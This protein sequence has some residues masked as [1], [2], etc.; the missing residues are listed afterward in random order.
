MKQQQFLD[1]LPLHEA[2]RRWEAA[3]DL[4]P[5]PTE[6]VALDAAHGRTLAEDIVAPGDVPAFDRSNVDGFAVHAVDTFGASERHPVTLPLGGAAI[7]AGHVASV[8]LAPGTACAMATGG[9]V[10]RGADAIVMV[11][12]TE[13]D[14]AS[15]TI[16]RP[17]APGSRISLAGSD[18]ARGEIVLRRGAL[19]GARETGTL[20]AC[21]LASVPCTGT[22]R[23][24][25]LSTG[26]EI[27]PPGTPLAPG[28]VHDANATLLADALREMGAVPHILGIARDDEADL[29][30][31]LD[32]ARHDDAIL[33][34]G[35]TS[36]GRGD[37]T[38]RVL[39]AVAEPVVHGVAL[40]PGKPLCLSAWDGKPVAILPGFPTSAIFT[41]HAVVAPVLRRLLGR[42][43]DEAA[44]V[45]ARLPRHVRSVVG[46]REFHLVSLVQGRRGYLAFPL[47]GGSG[48][49]TT[50]ARADGFF[51]MASD[52]EYAEADEEVIVTLLGKDV[53][54][55]DLVILGSHCPGVD[56]VLAAVAEMGF[57]AKVITTGSRGGVEAAA[58]GACDIAP[59]HLLHEAQGRWNEPFA[60]DGVRLL[61]GYV[62]QQGLAYRPEN[63]A[64]LSAGDVAAHLIQALEVGALRVA[65][66]N[67]GSGTRILLEAL[68]DG[69]DVTGA[70]GW[71]TAYRSHTAVAS[72]I[73]QGR[74]DFG[75]CL[76]QAAEAAGLAW[77][78]WREEH[79]DFLV[80]AERWERAAVRAFREALARPDIRAA[81]DAAGY[82]P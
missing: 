22:V 42:R 15:V 81:L 55:A 68:L 10:P 41:F 45:R 8:E 23:V 20:A 3:L 63:A 54:A 33:L 58:D 4:A 73:A 48:S 50:F 47:G 76:R 17:V 79:L 80:P 40:K 5:R 51:D 72:A 75:V 34:S 66:R 39:H 2:R 82:R 38:Y 78:P 27:V 46:R 62:R 21:G 7:D 61:P 44:R 26:D 52:Q 57:D 28:Q 31:M 12:D 30:A 69:R 74:A 25:I 19:L 70:P 64:Q 35:G 16:R 36:K 24:A 60:A 37:L 43:E 53:R 56:L 59:I 32:R 6:P 49:V 11:E 65:N 9:V 13:S 14:G 18:I 1:V 77:R 67:P 29:R 71:S